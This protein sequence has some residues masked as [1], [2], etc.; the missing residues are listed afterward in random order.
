MFANS[1]YHALSFN[2]EGKAAGTFAMA[3]KIDANAFEIVKV[4]A[5]V[6][7]NAQS[8][9]GAEFTVKYFANGDASGDPAKTW[10]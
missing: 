3:P 8:M 5:G 7:E 1:D 9:E 4:N 2:A 10:V 6:K